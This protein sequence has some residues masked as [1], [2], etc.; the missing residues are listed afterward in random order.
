MAGDW[1]RIAQQDNPMTELEL[2]Q[3]IN[4]INRPLQ[5]PNNELVNLALTS[6][7]A[8][9]SNPQ[10]DPATLSQALTHTGP[11][12]A[13]VPL[14]MDPQQHTPADLGG[15]IPSLSRQSTPN[16]STK[17]QRDNLRKTL[18]A[19]NAAFA[20]RGNALQSSVGE[21]EAAL[22]KLLEEKP[23]AFK[24]FNL[25]P[26]LALTDS[27]T[28]SKLSQ[29]YKPP[30][31]QM[32]KQFKAAALED[33]LQTQREKLAD[34]ELNAAK[35][36]LMGEKELND[37]SLEEARL[38]S[39]NQNKF[40]GMSSK[41]SVKLLK[42][43]KR[44]IKEHE[45]SLNGVMNARAMLAAGKPVGDA[46]FKTMFAKA[47]GQKG[48]FSDYDIQQYKGNPQLQAQA[49]QAWQ[50]YIQDGKLTP[51]N[52][53]D[54]TALLKV[55]EDT[56]KQMINDTTDIYADEYAP[57]AYNIEPD[58]AR[59]FLTS[60]YTR[61]K[62][63]EKMDQAQSEKAELEAAYKDPSLPASLKKEIAEKLGLKP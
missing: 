50:T 51:E 24:N 15:G 42:D 43:Y 52:R 49:M 19:Q 6:G 3:Q 12:P 59:K 5:S 18:E 63:A 56:N 17:A 57:N 38:N 11:Q 9:A 13:P 60:R 31:D 34:N 39:A 26:L 23:D 25:S 4:K 20:T 36:A 21:N 54:F 44:D 32:E 22:K 14:P 37:M 46:A 47:T 61:G 62:G 1:L 16:Y 58:K 28:G 30:T 2:A 41:D 48:A 55:M 8:P 45:D 10:F 53:Q 35:L 7:P 33:K 40:T 29:G 27:W